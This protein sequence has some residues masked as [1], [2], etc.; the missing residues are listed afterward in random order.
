[1]KAMILAAGR[2]ERMRPLTDSTPKPL[3]LVGGRPLIE[4]HLQRLAQAGVNEVVINTA[5]LGDQIQERLG[6]VFSVSDSDFNKPAI[7]S[8][9]Y[10]TAEHISGQSSQG[11]K[12]NKNK[13]YSLSIL[14]SKET[15]PLETAG[16]ILHAL[17]LLGEA[18]FLLING[19]VW[20]DYPFE[21]L[22][23]HYTAIGTSVHLQS[24]AHVV[25][26]DNPEH[27]VTGDFS[28]VAENSED[29][30]TEGLNQVLSKACL[31]EKQENTKTFTFSGISV[32]NPE[33]VTAYPDKREK[34]P[35]AEILHFGVSQQQISAEVYTGQW[36]DIGT[37]ERLQAL[38]DDLNK[39]QKNR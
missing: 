7:K 12:L 33:L 6:D 27:N 26:V 10:P 20:T 34:F 28:M 31:S 22:L 11:A 29:N 15:E 3:L 5:Y 17:P 14:Y 16:A 39:E 38:D 23:N 9:D 37:I 21:S 13:A 25:L 4:Y 32:I 35:L 8:A 1:L 2:G 19:D 36:R 18:P 30:F 24:L